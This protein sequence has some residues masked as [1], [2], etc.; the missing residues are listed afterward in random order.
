[1]IP[2]RVV[3]QIV[4]VGAALAIAV[5][6]VPP[7]ESTDAAANGG[8][9]IAVVNPVR[10]GPT[11][12]IASKEIPGRGH[13]YRFEVW[14]SGL[15]PDKP[16]LADLIIE[17]PGGRQAIGRWD[18]EGR[19]GEGSVLWRVPPEWP[20]GIYTLD[21]VLQRFDDS[22]FWHEIAVDSFDVRLDADANRTSA[23]VVPQGS[24]FFKHKGEPLQSDV[25]SLAS[26]GTQWVRFFYSTTSRGAVPV[27]R[28]CDAPRVGEGGDSAH[29][30]CV[31]RH[32]DRPREVKWLAA[33]ANDTPSG[34]AADPSLDA[35]SSVVDPQAYRAKP[36]IFLSATALSE[37][38]LEFVVHFL[39]HRGDSL[40]RA[41]VDLHATRSRFATTGSQPDFSA[42]DK[43]P[44]RILSAPSCD[45]DLSE[46]RQG[47]HRHGGPFHVEGETQGADPLEAGALVRSGWRIKAWFDFDR[48]DVKDRNESHD[49]L[50]LGEDTR[51]S[52]RSDKARIKR[53]RK[54]RLY[55]SFDGT[56]CSEGRPVALRRRVG[57]RPW[58]TIE[59]VVSSSYGSYSFEPRVRRRA[60]FKVV[61]P[62]SESCSRAASRVVTIRIKR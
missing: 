32:R 41:D 39:G 6:G 31:L 53:G 33:V 28:Y 55:G 44:H 58:K 4:G 22:V 50:F 48:D 13:S 60:R 51:P 56:H 3:Q 61:S 40:V 54:A 27:W 17:G 15:D 43:G 19:S 47:R 11:P 29:G 46:G 26:S 7:L 21:A 2:R 23:G 9:R 20:S 45:T 25:Q 8:E 16:Y 57:S 30:F 14:W 12:V 38:C 49:A 59:D 24:G 35:A 1:M 52:L 34:V 36:R 62:Q 37:S 10:V 5:V 42:P 18:P